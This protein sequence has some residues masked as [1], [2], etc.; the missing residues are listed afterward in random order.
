MTMKKS[1]PQP[2]IELETVEII[3]VISGIKEPKKKRVRKTPLNKHF[4]SWTEDFFDFF[5]K[6]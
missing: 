5:W 1:K 4:Y 6:E 2:V 3:H